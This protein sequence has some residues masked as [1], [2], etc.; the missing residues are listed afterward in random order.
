MTYYLEADIDSY[1]LHQALTYDPQSYYSIKTRGGSMYLIM[2]STIVADISF[3]EIS[4]L[5]RQTRGSP[6]LWGCFEKCQ[7]FI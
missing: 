7:N 2:C 3:Q 6:K 4:M 1:L 5:Q